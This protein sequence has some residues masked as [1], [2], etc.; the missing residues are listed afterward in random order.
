MSVREKAENMRY[1]VVLVVLVMVS[2]M[3]MSVSDE[4]VHHQSDA[5]THV[6]L[7]DAAPSHH[8][9]RRQVH[10]LTPQERSQVVNHHNALR[11][12]EGASDMELMSWDESLAKKA[13][14]W[15]AA[16]RYHHKAYGK[17]PA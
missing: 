10:S 9:H 2:V 6:H 17:P 7:S 5:V 13:Q 16:C 11:A 8:R 1:V 4:M 12:Q 14:S 3:T 15:A